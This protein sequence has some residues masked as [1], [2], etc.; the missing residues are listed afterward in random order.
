MGRLSTIA[1]LLGLAGYGIMYFGWCELHNAGVSFTEIWSPMPATIAK[2]QQ[3]LDSAPICQGSSSPNSQL[4]AV[5]A[6]YTSG[7]TIG[8]GTAPTTLSA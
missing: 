4:G 2:V 8:T 6:G 3:A 5:P 1:I 7:S